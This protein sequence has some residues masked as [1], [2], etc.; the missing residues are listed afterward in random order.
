MQSPSAHAMDRGLN[1]HT[2][3][4]RLK[5]DSV[6]RTGHLNDSAFSSR[7][8]SSSGSHSHGHSA[9]IP[10]QPHAIPIPRLEL[11]HHHDSL[12]MDMNG[13]SSYKRSGGF[14]E[15]ANR[16]SMNNSPSGSYKPS[17]AGFMEQANRQSN[18]SGSYKPS[19]GFMEQANRQSMNKSPGPT[20]GFMEHAN[21][22]RK[23]S[24]SF[25]PQVKTDSGKQIPLQG[26]APRAI[27]VEG[28]SKKPYIQQRAPARAYTWS[29]QDLQAS[30]GS[31]LRYQGG[32][33]GYGDGN[34]SIRR[35]Q[36]DACSPGG[37]DQMSSLTSDSTMSPMSEDLRTPP[38]TADPFGLFFPSS[39]ASSPLNENE[40][41]N[42]C[43]SSPRRFSTSTRN[44]S[45]S[46]LDGGARSRSRR[47]SVRSASPR[48]G[49]GSSQLSPANMVGSF[50]SVGEFFLRF[51]KAANNFTSS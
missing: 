45:Y 9:P 11:D 37:T 4:A 24:I 34:G 8:G 16:Q 29:E 32:Q 5:I 41:D 42:T 2:K 26:Q 44:K 15:Q 14:M 10:M 50:H 30:Q 36:R 51:V 48:F 25:D 43:W 35:R 13:S 3:F 28:T 18:L 27:N 23:S 6:P 49:D 40:Q 31:S 1:V 19:G 46:S 21:R 39:I 12:D 33:F 20:G 47:N 22:Q 38:P 7:N 17:T